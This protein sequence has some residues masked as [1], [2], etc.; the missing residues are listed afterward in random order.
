MSGSPSP[1]RRDVEISID[2]GA[3]DAIAPPPEPP[4]PRSRRPWP[5]LPLGRENL[6]LAYAA[7]V[8]VLVAAVVAAVKLSPLNRPLAEDTVRAYLEAVREGDVDEAL[9]YTTVDE[10]VGGFVEPEALDDSWR[11]VTVAQ[12]DYTERPSDALAQV[13]AEIEADDGTRAGF[14]YRVGIGHGQAEIENALTPADL[15]APFDHFDLNGVSVPVEDDM[16]AVEVMLLPGVYR[17]YPELPS[18]MEFESEPRV[19]ALGTEFTP[20]GED[21]SDTWLFLP[22]ILLS[23]EGIEAVDAALR[24]RLDACAADPALDACAF[25]FPEDPDREVSFAPG[26]A[27]EITAYPQWQTEWWWYETGH[28][29][30]LVTT[31]PGEAR[32]EVVVTE[33]GQ[34]RTATVSCP[35]WIDGLRAE[36]DFEGG[37]VVA[38]APEGA[39][40]QCHS[41]VEIG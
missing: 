17:F 21:Y 4:P 39:N 12:V 33:G 27:W 24:G 32:T 3:A 14:R 11:V 15:L 19:L 8:I 1:D 41:L 23:G 7:I 36:L 40:D 16:G 37:A 9:S 26:A 5:G 20:L 35:I 10:P 34:E 6:L 2:L 38:E 28:G 22:A 13:Y 30:A 29:F 18:T 31:A 25:G